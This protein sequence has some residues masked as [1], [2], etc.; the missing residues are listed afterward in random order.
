MIAIEEVYLEHLLGDCIHYR[1]EAKK[2]LR[3][4]P[5]SMKLTDNPDGGKERKEGMRMTILGNGALRK[6]REKGRVLVG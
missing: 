4:N 2:K 3:W 6:H 5:W 1:Q